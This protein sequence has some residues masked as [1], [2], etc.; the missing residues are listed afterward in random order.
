MLSQWTARRMLGTTTFRKERFKLAGRL[1]TRMP[2]GSLRGVLGADSVPT[3][4][5]ICPI[6]G[7]MR[8]VPAFWVGYAAAVW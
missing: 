4:A 5:G 6:D 1:A 3:I 2:A 8:A 7:F